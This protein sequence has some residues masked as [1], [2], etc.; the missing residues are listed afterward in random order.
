MREGNGQ[1]K[2]PRG[3]G[4]LNADSEL[5]HQTLHFHNSYIRPL[6]LGSMDGNERRS[7]GATDRSLIYLL[8][9]IESPGTKVGGQMTVLSP[10]DT[11][12]QSFTMRKTVHDKHPQPL[13]MSAIYKDVW[14][15]SLISVYNR[16]CLCLGFCPMSL[17]MLRK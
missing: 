17:L 1:G 4:D 5:M 9:Q 13:S 10:S 6:R 14:M 3:E 15:C 2:R 8:V 16:V 12:F 11:P 7:N